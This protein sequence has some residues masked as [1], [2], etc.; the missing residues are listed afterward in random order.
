MKRIIA[1]SL[2]LS[3]ASYASGADNNSVKTEA[4]SFIEKCSGYADF[5]NEPLGAVCETE[6]GG[7]F[8]RVE[9]DG[10][11]GLHDLNSGLV[12]MYEIMTNASYGDAKTFCKYIDPSN[13]NYK[14]KRTRLPTI[15]EFE[16]LDKNGFREAFAGDMYGKR[17]WSSEIIDTATDGKVVYSFYPLY[18]TS[19]YQRNVLSYGYNLNARCV[20][21]LN[22]NFSIDRARL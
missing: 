16:A 17:F 6:K 9:I 8:A 18:G 15:D 22:L 20:S 11:D 2:A 4:D 19:H 1:L 5:K 10:E 13:G 21:I 3:T 14:S 12:V 7:V